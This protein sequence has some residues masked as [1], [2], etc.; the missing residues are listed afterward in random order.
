MDI[1]LNCC[2]IKHIISK[3]FMAI[4]EGD[5]IFPKLYRAMRQRFTAITNRAENCLSLVCVLFNSTIL[6]GEISMKR[7]PVKSVSDKR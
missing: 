2:N 3:L 1:A 4:I 7:N 6:C 5:V